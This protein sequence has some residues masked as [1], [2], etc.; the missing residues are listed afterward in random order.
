[1]TLRSLALPLLL[2]VG[3]G[4]GQTPGAPGEVP[5]TLALQLRE[6]FDRSLARLAASGALGANPQQ[7]N[8]T[9]EEPSR[10]IVDLGVLVDS[11]SAERARDGLRVLGTTPGSAAAAAGLRPGDVIVA[12]NG[13]SL[14]DLG[15]DGDGHALAAD[16]LREAVMS[17]ADGATLH[18]ELRRDGQPLVVDTTVRGVLVPAMRVE[19]G[20]AAAGGCG[21]ISTFDVAPR[22][23]HQ[24]HARILLLDG[25][26]P[27]PEGHETYRV[28]AGTHKLLVAEDIPTSEI[29][30]G[31]TAMLRSQRDTHKELTVTVK[32]NTTLLIAAQLH[33]DKAY[34]TTHAAY[35]DPVVWR[36]LVETCP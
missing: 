21:R 2:L 36:E 3:V 8:L 4:H 17:A 33:L 20:A 32:P 1:M 16:R 19:L 28:P 24:Y 5:R 15:A 30:V 35:W 10:R 25:T 7:V 23:E 27:G 31:V 9:M 6:E 26:T 22:S 14:R 29:G 34:Q 13:V 11:S 12:V 18:L